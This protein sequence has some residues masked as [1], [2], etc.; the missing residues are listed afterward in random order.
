VSVCWNGAGS[1]T[2]ALHRERSPLNDISAGSLLLKPRDFDID[3]LCEFEPAIFIVTPVLKAFDGTR[4]PGPD[5]LTKILFSG[6]SSRAKTYFIYGGGWPADPASPPG[7]IGNSWFGTSYNQAILN[8]P[9]ERA[10]RMGDYAFFR[11]HQSEGILL[12]FGPLLVVEDGHVVDE[13]AP[14]TETG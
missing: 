3:L 7:L 12:Q 5:W 10:L 4:I 6:R 14:F 13:W 9:A 2:V 1:P 8:G 11:P